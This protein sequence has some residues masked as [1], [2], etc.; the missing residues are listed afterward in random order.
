[1][2]NWIEQRSWLQQFIA[3]CRFSSENVHSV[4]VAASSIG[5]DELRG[6]VGHL[7]EA[8]SE[9]ALVADSVGGHSILSRILVELAGRL[10]NDASTRV[11]WD[12]PARSRFSAIC[13]SRS[14]PTSEGLVGRPGVPVNPLFGHMVRGSSSDECCR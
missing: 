3:V 4:K 13:E 7:F 5:V 9:T 14:G 1:M 6:C 8:R 10:S 11:Q 2:P 12:E